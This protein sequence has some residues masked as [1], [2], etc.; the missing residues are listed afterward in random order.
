ME[1]SP[2]RTFQRKNLSE[3]CVV[4]AGQPCDRRQFVGPNVLFL[5]I[6]DSFIEKEIF[7]AQDE[8][9]RQHFAISIRQR[10]ILMHRGFMRI[11]ASLIAGTVTVWLAVNVNSVR[12][13]SLSV[14]G[15]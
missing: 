15:S 3:L 14:S 12:S 11:F 4:I 1:R 5:V 7:D 9:I 6:E 13:I 10:H 8:Q 2:L